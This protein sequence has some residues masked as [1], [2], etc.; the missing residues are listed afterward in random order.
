MPTPPISI[1]PN[2]LW[3]VPAVSPGGLF[4]RFGLPNPIVL[5]LSC[6]LNTLYN[7]VIVDA[8][9]R[10]RLPMWPLPLDLLAALAGWRSRIRALK[11]SINFIG[12]NHYYRENCSLSF[13]AFASGAP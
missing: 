9:T 10:G 3:F 1:A 2:V 12:L 11:G 7:F 5:L 8:C 6:I 13:S 4:G